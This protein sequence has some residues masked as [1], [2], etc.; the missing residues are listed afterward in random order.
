MWYN[1]SVLYSFSAEY[2][3]FSLKNL[4][5]S[6]NLFSEKNQAMEVIACKKAWALHFKSYLIRC[7]IW[8]CNMNERLLVKVQRLETSVRIVH[9]C[10]KRTYLGGSMH[11][12]FMRF[13]SFLI[14][15]F[16]EILNFLISL[17]HSRIHSA[18]YLIKYVST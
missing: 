16:A 5:K 18:T 1:I 6:L 3:Y 11:Q 10:T 4:Y 12:F 14:A 15:L 9:K 8:W 13:C 2:M 17:S 7:C